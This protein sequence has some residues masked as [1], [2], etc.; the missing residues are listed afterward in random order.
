[1]QVVFTSYVPVQRGGCL[2]K[3]VCV[4]MLFSQH[5]NRC[6]KRW[7]FSVLGDFQNSAMQ[8]AEN[9][10]LTLKISMC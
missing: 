9:P 5:R 10:D 7:K 8:V 3:P 6:P 1:M 2:D 4:G